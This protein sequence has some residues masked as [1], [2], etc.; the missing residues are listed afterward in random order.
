MAGKREFTLD[1][2]RILESNEYTLY[3]TE[4][5]IVHTQEFKEM[6]WEMYNNGTP[7]RKIFKEYGYDSEILGKRRICMYPSRL[8]E[9]LSKYGEFRA[10]KPK[11]KLKP[12][13][14]TDY[15]RMQERKSMREMQN[16]IK[17]LRQ[18]IDFL[19]KL[20]ELAK[21]KK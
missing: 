5:K 1:E 13:R 7:P 14:N 3:A 2:I 21:A 16:E 15:E 12:P 8:K 11:N 20:I 10:D 6:F 18:E 17:Y 19:K 9:E 4:H